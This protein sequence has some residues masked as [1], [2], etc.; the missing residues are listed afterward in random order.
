[1]KTFPLTRTLIE[2]NHAIDAPDPILYAE[3]NANRYI[4]S[5]TFVVNDTIP[6]DNAPNSAAYEDTRQEAQQIENGFPLKSVVS[7][8]RGN[9]SGYVI[10]GTKYDS[11]P[12][13]INQKSRTDQSWQDDPTWLWYGSQSYQYWTSSLRANG[14]GHLP[15]DTGNIE[16]TWSGGKKINKLRILFQAA[17]ALPTNWKIYLYVS[18]GGGVG[19]DGPPYD[20]N[21]N[22]TTDE[23]YTEGGSGG[24][25]G[26]GENEWVLISSNASIPTDRDFILYRDTIGSNTEAGDWSQSVTRWTEA[27]QNQT[28]CY[29]IRIEINQ[30]T[31][32][33]G[34]PGIVEISPRLE[35]DLSDLLTAWDY[36]EELANPSFISPI[37]EASANTGSVTLSNDTG[38]FNELNS[39]SPF[40]KL[41]DEEVR[42]NGY[43]KYDTETIPIFST[44][45]D[46]WSSKDFEPVTVQM[47]DDAR[48][49]Q[50]L[51]CCDMILSNVSVGTAFHMMFASLGL[52]Q[53]DIIET[54]IK[55]M[56]TLEKF[57]TKKEDKVWDIIQSVCKSLQIGAVFDATGS[58]RMHTKEAIYDHDAAQVYGFDSATNG[59]KVSDIISLERGENA[60]YN[61]VT[62]KYSAINNLSPSGSQNQTMWTAPDTW[63]IGAA[64]IVRNISAGDTYFVIDPNRE[65][66]LPR[67]S[68]KVVIE[69]MANVIEWEGKDF[70]CKN[71]VG[72]KH[73]KVTK[74]S[75]F[76]EALEQNNGEAPRFTG[77][78]FLKDDHVFHRDYYAKGLSFRQDWDTVEFSDGSDNGVRVV[79]GVKHLPKDGGLEVVT[80]YGGKKRLNIS[81]KAQSWNKYDKVGMKFKVNNNSSKVGLVVWQRGATG[82]AGYYFTVDPMSDKEIQRVR[83]KNEAND[84]STASAS[85]E[86]HGFYVGLNGNRHDMEF[87][88]AKDYK[89]VPPL[90]VD[91]WSYL[92]V[93]VYEVGGGYEFEVFVNGQYCKT[94]KDPSRA[95][96][97]NERAGM[98]FMNTGKVKLE[99][100]YV[101]TYPES[102]IR[103]KD[104]DDSGWLVRRKDLWEDRKASQAD[105]KFE[106]YLKSVNRKKKTRVFDFDFSGRFFA[107]A[108]ERVVE[109]VRFDQ[110]AIS[111]Q[112]VCTN[113][114]ISVLDYR[115]SAFGA[116]IV[117]LNKSERSQL[118]KGEVQTK[119]SGAPRTQ[120]SYIYGKSFRKADSQEVEYRKDESIDRIGPLPLEF[121][122]DW[123]QDRETA[124]D[125]A[126]WVVDRF[127]ENA[128]IYTMA[129]FGNPLIEVADIIAV[130]WPE[131]GIENTEKWVVTAVNKSWS[132]GLET[133]LTIRRII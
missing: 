46:S 66:D 54:R 47:V 3:W 35:A 94:F 83:A 64:Q 39:A 69:N 56:A 67:Y 63:T 131:K 34:R 27:A 59:A 2:E 122:S 95:F 124:E 107:I 82:G 25:S 44:L 37:G 109:R 72:D 12:K 105:K 4:I 55:E 20:E 28:V 33:F 32:P 112:F 11:P 29:G 58:L 13:F 78:I 73:I 8:N 81:R 74:P 10:T 120:S 118:L 110:P 70:Y 41:L 88:R 76:Q 53:F 113:H 52:P 80:S 71:S 26:T 117:F 90:R 106:N 91:A 79:T 48:H 130:D 68:G 114:A 121:E 51:E 85:P 30:V 126:K 31:K 77:R 21:V 62:I 60:R 97:R 9:K 116:T 6:V 133:S 40:Y 103:S 125:L 42:F 16:Y 15:F 104:D 99:K 111:S 132:D 50:N 1:M 75:E 128:E 127:N 49:L 14:N 24:G 18:S 129:V 102:S 45:S 38:L 98:T 23:V 108:R 43:L 84:D 22:Y 57:Y 89:N 87:D 100:F 36:N 123:I 119:V 92:E 65:E 86:I 96:S 5:P 7:Q 93:T 19:F 17:H 101:I 115:P 61:K